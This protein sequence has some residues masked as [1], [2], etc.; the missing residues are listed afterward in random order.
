MKIAP[1]GLGIWI[2]QLSQCES[3]DLHKILDRC[4]NCGIKW[5][6]IKSGDGSLSSGFENA[7]SVISELFHTNGI[8]VYTWNYSKPSTWHREVDQIHFLS[9]TGID[10]HI[11]KAEL[12][13]QTVSDNQNEATLFLKA[14]RNAVGE[15]F[16]GY[17]T[18]A[19][20]NYHAKF[21]YAQFSEFCDAVFPQLYWTEFNWDVQK[22]ISMTDSAWNLFGINNPLLKKPVWPVAG[23]YGNEIPGVQ[24]TFKALDMVKFVTHYSPSPISLYCYDTASLNPNLIFDFLLAR[25]GGFPLPVWEMTEEDLKP[26]KILP[27]AE[28]QVPE[29]PVVGHYD[30][31]SK[32]TF[33]DHILNVLKFLFHIK[34]K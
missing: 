12:E 1:E 2:D 34:H 31:T 26:R 28:V 17:S 6:C 9:K 21:P 18:F 11:V 24:G 19:I 8:K 3:G 23:A 22:A 5:I 20:V 33:G 14:L 32:R 25:H 10:G 4:K 30:M 7:I 15:M 29:V 13:W 16:L 27:H